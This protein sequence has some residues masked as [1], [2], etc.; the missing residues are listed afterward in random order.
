MTRAYI[1]L[2]TNLGDCEKN[3]SQARDLLAQ[4]QRSSVIKFSSVY[5]SAPWGK[6]DQPDFLNQVG[7]L[8]TELSAHEMLEAILAIEKDMG[9]ERHEKWGPRL[10]DLDLLLFGNQIIDEHE[11][12]IPHQFLEE[13]AFVVVPLLELEPELVLPNGKALKVAAKS[14]AES[15]LEG[16]ILNISMIK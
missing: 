4:M 8:E 11:L 2:G 16:C 12:K 10:I 6:I 14:L 9:R 1:G 15:D 7:I 13:R 5:R 3:L